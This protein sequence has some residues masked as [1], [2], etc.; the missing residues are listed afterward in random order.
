LVN[1]SLILHPHYRRLAIKGNV[2][3]G[4]NRAH[5]SG[6]TVKGKVTVGE[7]LTTGI[8][9][10]IKDVITLGNDAQ[11]TAGI[12]GRSRTIEGDT[13]RVAAIDEEGIPSLE[14]GEGACGNARE[15]YADG[16]GAGEVG[17]DA[18]TE[19]FSGNPQSPLPRPE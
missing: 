11:V 12:G 7:E 8:G 13:A 15:I 18:L 10:T 14:G 6:V 9:S 1:P 16:A 17:L 3:L 5:Q 4:V 19:L 2:T